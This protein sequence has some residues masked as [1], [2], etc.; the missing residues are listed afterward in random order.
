MPQFTAN[1]THG[2]IQSI[3]EFFRAYNVYINIRKARDT[4]PASTLCVVCIKEE[5]WAPFIDEHLSQQR[6]MRQHLD[7]TMRDPVEQ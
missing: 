6:K 2:E 4:G 3:L 5:K 1:L 7:N